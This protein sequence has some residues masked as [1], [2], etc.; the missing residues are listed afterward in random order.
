V[1][2]HADEFNVGGN[3]TY[4]FPTFA[5][6][7]IVQTDFAEARVNVRGNGKLFLS[8][9]YIEFEDGSSWGNNT[10]GQAEYVSAY[11]LGEKY[12]VK[13]IRQLLGDK[14]KEIVSELLKRKISEINLPG[15]DSNKTE[16]EQR[17]FVSGFRAILIRLQ[18][19]YEKQG[20]DGISPKLEEIEKSL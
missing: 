5:P 18:F 14:N 16:K 7:Q 13:Y 6:G 3:S 12:G 17:G 20:V 11:H 10:K 15:I 19:V 8:V 2:L 4:I 1:I 9:D